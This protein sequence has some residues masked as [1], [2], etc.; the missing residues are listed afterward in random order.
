MTKITI[1]KALLEQAIAAIE[2]AKDNLR[3]HDDNC[4]LHDDGEY[5]SCFCG[6]D[7]LTGHLLT[8]T[9]SIEA[10]LEEP[11]VEPAV[12]PVAEVVTTMKPPHASPVWLPFKTIYAS[13]KWLDSVPVGT[14]L[15]TSP[16]P[17][18][19]VPM[20]TDDEI[21]ACY[22]SAR[23]SLRQYQSKV[24]GQQI[25]PPDGFDWHFARSIQAAVRQKAGL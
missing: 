21:D 18:A 8:V 25:M 23:I 13:L 11:V 19:D 15:Y 6:L 17:P 3:S 14:K 22:E 1:D 4:F 2:L 16:P 9:E 5:N 12:E 20:L 24:R 10:A 7:S